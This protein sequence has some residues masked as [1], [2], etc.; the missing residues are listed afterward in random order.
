MRGKDTDKILLRHYLRHFFRDASNAF[1]D[2]VILEIVNFL[3]SNVDARRGHISLKSFG[4]YL[5]DN[6]LTDK[7]DEIEIRAI[8]I[9]RQRHA[10]VAHWGRVANL[11]GQTIPISTEDLDGVIELITEVMDYVGENC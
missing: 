9:I 1:L 5:T 8:P 2:A 4:L 11:H 3:D 10:F 7:I 6:V